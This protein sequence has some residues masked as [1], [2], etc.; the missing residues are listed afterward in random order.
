MVNRFAI[1]LDENPADVRTRLTVVPQLTSG[2]LVPHILSARFWQMW[3]FL[4][5]SRAV[6]RRLL[7]SG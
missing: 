5:M 3:F 2:S 4:H 6:T 1:C 7:V